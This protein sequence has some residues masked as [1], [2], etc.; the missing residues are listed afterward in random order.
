MGQYYPRY[1]RSVYQ[2][3]LDHCEEDKTR[4]DI[5]DIEMKKCSFSREGLLAVHSIVE[6]IVKESNDGFL[7]LGM[8]G[9]WG[10][11]GGMD[12]RGKTRML[13]SI[14]QYK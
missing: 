7:V 4:Q 2:S 5:G 11:W 13:L 14:I 8:C 12:T 6:A 10:C 1:G 3:C 9:C